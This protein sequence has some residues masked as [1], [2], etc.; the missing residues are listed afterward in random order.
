MKQDPYSTGDPRASFEVNSM[1]WKSYAF[2]GDMIPLNESQLKPLRLA[3]HAWLTRIGLVM[4]A[5]MLLI[6]SIAGFLYSLRFRKSARS[7]PSVRSNPG[8]MDWAKM[9]LIGVILPII[10][11]LVITRRTALSGNS[12]GAGY[13]GLFF[14]GFHLAVLLSVLWVTPHFV[15]QKWMAH[16]PDGGSCNRFIFITLLLLLSTTSLIA[17]PVLKH[18]GRNQSVM[19]ILLLPVAAVIGWLI[20]KALALRFSRNTSLSKDP[21]RIAAVLPF[22][23][24][25]IL[26]LSVLTLFYARSDSNWQAQDTLLHI[27]PNTP[28]TG[29]FEMKIAAQ[30]RL[31]IQEITGIK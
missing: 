24:T 30:K 10:V 16:E 23:A 13:Y 25:G 14:P 7:S 8:L 12:Y 27:H 6:S 3:E 15:I 21:Y 28:D 1:M 31:S 17:W 18:F 29:I 22:R 19:M 5:I 2:I 9:L 20:F 26:C 11:Y 4:V